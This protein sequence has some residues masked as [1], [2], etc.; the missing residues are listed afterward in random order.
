MVPNCTLLV[1]VGEVKGT[2]VQLEQESGEVWIVR[3][4]ARPRDAGVA[5]E[6]LIMLTLHNG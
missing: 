2:F 4:V 6:N 3:N 1:A 5:S